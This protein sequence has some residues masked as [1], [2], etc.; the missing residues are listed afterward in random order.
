LRERDK[1]LYRVRVTL[2][3]LKEAELFLDTHPECAEAIGYYQRVQKE[4]G[5]AIAAY[6]AAVGPLTSAHGIR[7]GKWVWD[8]CPWPWMMEA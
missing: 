3:Q 6:E 8:D 1:L 4:A 7:N 5:E 2:F